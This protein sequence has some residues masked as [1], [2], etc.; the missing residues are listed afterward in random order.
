MPEGTLR[1]LQG[2]DS[3]KA[4][5]CPSHLS[6]N[7]ELGL[8]DARYQMLSHAENRLPSRLLINK[9]VRVAAREVAR[10]SEMAS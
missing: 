9:A 2:R 10:Q 4:S 7:G 1:E 8:A 6:V 3:E 5:P